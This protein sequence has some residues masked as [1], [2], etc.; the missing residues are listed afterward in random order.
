MRLKGKQIAD[1]TITQRNLNLTTP[2][3]NTDAATKEYVD[4]MISVEHLSLANK[5]MSALS[6]SGITGITLA[7][8]TPILEPPITNSQTDVYINNL[9]IDSGPNKAAF[10]SGNSG[11]TARGVGETQLGDYLYWN[12]L[13]AEYELEISDSIDFSYL[14]H[15]A[16]SETG[17]IDGGVI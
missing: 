12:M 14:I 2:S 4:S 17:V 8:S 3:G 15:G 13:I 10:F 6:T 7:C 11:I 9:L 1:S 16:S 5:N